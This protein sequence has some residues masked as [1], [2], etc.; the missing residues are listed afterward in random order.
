MAVKSVVMALSHFLN[1]R[2]RSW[3][4]SLPLAL[5]GLNDLPGLVAP[6]SPH[7]QV[8]RRDPVGFGEVPPPVPGDGAEDAQQFFSRLVTERQQVK[9][10]LKRLHDKASNALRR[11]LKVQ[12]FRGGDRV[13]LRDRPK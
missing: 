10:A 3:Y 13:W 8:F 9:T 4:H 2:P 11:K 12:P 7:R 6:Y 1:Q 5:W